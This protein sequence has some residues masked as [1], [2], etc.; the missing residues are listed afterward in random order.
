MAS[1]VGKISADQFAAAVKLLGDFV[2]IPSVSHPTSPDYSMTH[3]KAAAVWASTQ[4]LDLGF[5]VSNPCVG[6]SAPYVVAQKIVNAAYPTIILYAHVDDQPVDRSKWTTKDP[7]IVEERDGRLYGRGASDDKG[8]LVAICA[9]VRAYKEAGVELPV[10]I[11]ILFEPEEEYES[12]HMGAFLQGPGQIFK[13]AH[14]LVIMDGLNRDVDS[15]TL[16]SSTRGLV[17]LFVRVDALAKPAHSGLACLVPDPAQMLARLVTSLSNPRAI[18]G[19]MDDCAQMSPED[20]AILDGSSQTAESYQGEQ[21]LKEGARLRGDPA[22]SVYRRIVDE[23]SISVVNMNC[24]QPN[25]GN[26]IQD[27]ASCQ[28]GI[29]VVPGQDPDRV[30]RVVKEYLLAQPNEYN[31]PIDVTQPSLGAWAW[32]ADL[33]GQFSTEYMKALAANFSAACAMPCGGALPLIRK[34]E[35]AFPGMEIIVPGVED[36]K[37]SAHSHDE[38]QDLGLLERAINSL[39]DFLRRAG[40]IQV[41]PSGTS[42]DVGEEEGASKA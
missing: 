17:N 35:Q 36:P 25:G 42:S 19:F 16:T 39:I 2:A 11:Q 1:T 3:L 21:G 28:I 24:G 5:T 22:K 30:G 37:T 41:A 6:D 38:S 23:P 12:V 20:Q 18:P 15:G 40:T 26:S 4:L 7:F 10:N 9:A 13:D 29:R 31:L 8:G 34:F 32:R 33:S 14:A 27:S